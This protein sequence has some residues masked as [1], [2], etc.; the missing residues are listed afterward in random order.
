MIAKTL[1]TS[2]GFALLTSDQGLA[3]PGRR[4]GLKVK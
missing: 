1:S 2:G 4:W 3:A